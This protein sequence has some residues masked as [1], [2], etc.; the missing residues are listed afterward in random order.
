MKVP[1]FLFSF[2]PAPYKASTRRLNITAQMQDRQRAETRRLDMQRDITLTKVR[3]DQLI[4]ANT[5][6]DN[7]VETKRL[8]RH[9][10]AEKEEQAA[11]ENYE[12]VRKY[13]LEPL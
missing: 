9:I 5:T 12:Q 10:S 1:P 3:N 13:V 8:L 7:R 11:Y 4:V 2:F 6:S